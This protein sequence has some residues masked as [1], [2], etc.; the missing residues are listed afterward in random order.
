MRRLAL[1]AP[2]VAF[3]LETR[4]ARGV[5]PAAQDRRPGSR[6]CSGRMPRRRCCLSRA[7]V[8][9]LRIE[10]FAA[11]PAVTRATAAAQGLTVNGRPVA[12]P[13]LKT[14]VRVA[15]RNVIAAGRHPVVA[16][17]LDLP[18]EELDVNVHPAKAEL[19]FRD[20][21]AVRGLVIG[22]LSRALA[23]SAPAHAAP[24]LALCAVLAAGGALLRPRHP[25]SAP[26][27]GRT[28]SSAGRA[29][30]RCA[31]ADAAPFTAGAGHAGNSSRWGRAV[32]Q[33][34]DT[35]IIAV[36]ATAAWCWWTS[37][38]RMSA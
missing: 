25:G 34:L 13:V 4:R 37:T 28:R 9:A 31:G 27:M 10:G 2:E 35:Y 6:R 23:R 26:G 38:P 5:R 33:V 21:R 1:A 8:A 22:A 29:A 17:Y 18:P 14:A 24:P 20:A 16:L 12:D 19:R 32:A 7:S 3:R 36:A 30:A 15:Y 11:S